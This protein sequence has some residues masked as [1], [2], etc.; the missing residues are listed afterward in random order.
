MDSDFKRPDPHPSAVRVTL[1]KSFFFLRYIF[2]TNISIFFFCLDIEVEPKSKPILQ[3]VN[4][5]WLCDFDVDCCPSMNGNSCAV[6]ILLTPACKKLT[7]VS[8]KCMLQD[9]KLTVQCLQ[10]VRY[11]VFPEILYPKKQ[12]WYLIITVYPHLYSK[13]NWNNR[14]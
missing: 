4:S 2:P 11:Q 7:T 14:L 13:E 5:Q 6:K 9:C 8:W 3:T 10:L 12:V 1:G